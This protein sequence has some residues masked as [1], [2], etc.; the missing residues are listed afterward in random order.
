MQHLLKRPCSVV[1]ALALLAA[2]GAAEF[3]SASHVRPKGASPWRA[4]LVPAYKQC[5]SPTGNHETGPASCVPPTPASDYLTVGTPDSNGA[6]VNSVSSATYT[7]KS[8]SPEDVKIDY[9]ITD[10]RCR[11]AATGCGSANSAD[12]PD[13]TG[14]L[15]AT[16]VNRITDHR[17]GSGG[18]DAG[19]MVDVGFLVWAPVTISCTQTS[20]D[21]TVGSTCAVSTTANALDGG[22]VED[23][24]RM[25]AQKIAP[26]EVV[27][28]GADSSAATP[29]NTLFMEEGIFVP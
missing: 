11:P 29:D 16:S 25:I 18:G 20:T 12:G 22:A 24:A 1:A 15:Q 8:T 9:E 13:Y 14:T 3:A 21:T 4:S 6:P 17:N 28:G 7:V 26:L 5:T 2:F 23:S 27:D 19:T 10:V